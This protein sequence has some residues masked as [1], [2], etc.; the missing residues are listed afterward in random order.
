MRFPKTINSIKMVKFN[1]KK[2]KKDPWITYGNLKILYKNIKKTNVDS[3]LYEDR[4]QEFKN[5]KKI[6]G[7]LIKQVKTLF[8]ETEFNRHRGNWKEL[9]M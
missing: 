7:I 6:L 3:P 4:K 5:Y 1:K 2:H 8:N 9:C